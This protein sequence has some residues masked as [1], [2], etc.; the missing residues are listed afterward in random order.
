MSLGPVMMDLAGQEL[1]VEERDMLRHPLTGAVILFARN[2]A[3]PEQIEEL[4]REIHMLREP[5]LLVAV[6]HEGGRVQRFRAGFTSLP[7]MRGLGHIYDTDRKRAK[8][9]AEACGWLMAGEL[10]AVGVDFSFAPVL[11]VDRGISQIIGDRAFHTNPQAVADLAHSYM[12]G[13]KHAGM[14]ATGKHFP[15]HGGVEADSHVAIPVDERNYNDIYAED[16]LPF[17][18]MIHYGLAAI[19]PAHVIYPQV[20]PHPAGFSPF[21]LREV[22]RKRLEFQGA[23]FSDDLS[24]EGATVAGDFVQRARAAL[25]AGCD[26]VLVC[27]NP[28]A[29]A[30]VLEGLGGYDDPVAYMR[31]VRMRGRGQITRVQLQRDPGWKQAVQALEKINAA[32]AG[33]EN[34]SLL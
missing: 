12:L 27:N 6:D 18:R 22:L 3:S 11:D 5:R 7:A 23:I 33:G 25:H 15:G 4:I 1:S 24:M 17:E 29:A 19:M 13:M 20:D 9:L 28:N 10:R 16:I 31:L 30:Q 34:L 21:W 8:R 14:A 26:M 32:Y 2:Y